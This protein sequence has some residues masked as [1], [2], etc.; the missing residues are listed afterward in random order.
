MAKAKILVVDDEEMTRKSLKDALASG[1]FETII[2]N[3]GAA[4]LASA[5]NEKPDLILT[6][7]KMPGL[8]GMGM[9]K[10]IRK[11]GDW[12]K[13]VPVMILTNFDTDEK[14]MQGIVEDE[15]S[16]YFLK[17]KVTP[18]ALVDKIKEKLEEHIHNGK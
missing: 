9:L 11:S 7:V 16:F 4:G 6:D 3:D 10:E 12:G 2:A 15:P 1:G 14:I 8:D 17:S 18:T 5:L 13:S